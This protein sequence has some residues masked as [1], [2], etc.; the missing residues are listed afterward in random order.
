MLPAKRVQQRFLCLQVGLGSMAAPMATTVGPHE[1]P[2]LPVD[3]SLLWGDIHSG[4]DDDDDDDLPYV[5][6]TKSFKLKRLNSTPRCRIH[7]GK[8]DGSSLGTARSSRGDG[9]PRSSRGDGTAR[10]SRGDG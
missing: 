7:T 8:G 1:I 3:P 9:T 10:S 4:E 5:S 6:K 2:A